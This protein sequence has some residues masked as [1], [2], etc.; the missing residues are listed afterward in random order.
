MVDLRFDQAPVPENA[1]KLAEQIVEPTKRVDGAALDYSENSLRDVDRIICGFHNERTPAEQVAH[2]VFLFGCYVGEVMVREIPG[3]WAMPADA[4][5]PKQMLE[6]FPFM[7][8]QTRSGFVLN[9]IAKAFKLLENGMEDSI[10]FLM[11]VA[12][13]KDRNAGHEA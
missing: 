8:V 4:G 7:I 2:T 5:V 3:R 9:P 1:A 13:A 10:Y 12:K 11:Q 6:H